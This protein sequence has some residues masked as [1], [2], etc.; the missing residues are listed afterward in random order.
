MLDLILVY[1]G[2][3]FGILRCE[4]GVRCLYFVCFRD[5]VGFCWFVDVLFLTACLGTL[6]RIPFRFWI[7]VWILGFVLVCGSGL[8]VCVLFWITIVAPY[9]FWG[10]VV[11]CIAVLLRGF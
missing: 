8:F 5:M 6:D 4:F 9:W 10:A 7:G 2:G 11:V 3:V 1:R